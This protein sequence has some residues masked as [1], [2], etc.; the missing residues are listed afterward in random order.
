[1]GVPCVVAAF[2][3][4]GRHA[5]RLTTV[6]TLHQPADDT[7]APRLLALGSGGATRLGAA[8]RL[9]AVRLIAGNGTGRAGAR[10]GALGGADGLMG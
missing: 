10:R 2:S 5:V 9:A 4:N 1:M 3:A 7:L 8:L 6:K